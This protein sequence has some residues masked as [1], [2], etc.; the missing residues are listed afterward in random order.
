MRT[1]IPRT[2]GWHRVNRAT[3]GLFSSYLNS[4]TPLVPQQ[5]ISFLREEQMNKL[6]KF[7]CR[8]PY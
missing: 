5:T 4:D 3:R 1:Q 2:S 7:I 6:K 8:Q